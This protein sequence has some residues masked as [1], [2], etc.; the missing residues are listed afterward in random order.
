MRKEEKTQLTKERILAAAEREFGKN[1]YAGTSMGQICGDEISKGLLYHNFEGKDALYL[2]CIARCFSELTAYLRGQAADTDLHGYLDA[3]RR[4]FREHES[5]ARLFFEA[6]LQPPAPLKAQIAALQE[7]FQALNRALYEKLLCSIPIRPDIT[8]ADA[9]EYFA[10]IQA[11]FNGYF[12]SPAYRDLS[13]SELVEAHEISLSR[14][15][16]FMLYGIAHRGD[17]T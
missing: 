3:R 5:L 9:M 11:L 14:V 8:R 12:S 7:E 16:D 1:G 13:F 6:V 17:K 15:L 10:L 4:F 2:A